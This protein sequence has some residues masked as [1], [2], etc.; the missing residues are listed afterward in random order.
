MQHSYLETIRIK[1]IEELSTTGGYATLDIPL[2]LKLDKIASLKEGTISGI[3]GVA[4][5]Q[6]KSLS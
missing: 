4:G 3:D 6:L 2:G 5:Q 1:A